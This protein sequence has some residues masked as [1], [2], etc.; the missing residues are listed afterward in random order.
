MRKNLLTLAAIAIATT[1][2]AQNLTLDKATINSTPLARHEAGEPLRQL[3]GKTAQ[4]PTARIVMKADSASAD[5]VTV[6]PPAGRLLDNM[7]VTSSGYGLGWGSI[8]FQNVDGGLGGVVEGDDGAVYVKAPISQAYVWMLGTPWIK[9]EKAEGDT[10]VMHTPQLYAIDAGDPYYIQRLTV[11]A[12]GSTYVVDSVDTD[13]RFVWRNDT[14]TQVDD[15]LAGLTDA[16]GEWFY[17]GDY[18]IVYTVN[19][20]AVATIPD[21]FASQTV[22]MTYKSNAADLSATTSQNIE[23]YADPE[24][25]S[26][27]AYFTNLETAL[28][29]SPIKAQLVDSDDDDDDDDDDTTRLVVSG[30][31]YLGID[32]TYNAHVYALT[33][34]AR[35]DSTDSKPFFNYDLVPSIEFMTVDEDADTARAEWPSALL[36]NCGRQNL[37][38]ISEFAAPVLVAKSYDA[39]V[40]ADPIFTSEDVR[41]STNFDLLH[42]TIPTT[43][44]DGNE[45]N[46]NALYYEIYLDGKPYT[47]TPAV[48]QGLTTDMT[49]IP[50]AF[51]DSYYDIINNNGRMTIYFYDHNDYDSIGVQSIYKAGGETNVSNIVYVGNPTTGISKAKATGSNAQVA[52]TYDIAGRRVSGNTRGIVIIRK[53]DGTITKEIK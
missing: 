31:Q 3:A 9:C 22:E 5:T 46:V 44:V 7:Y 13:I 25:D 33:A 48:F 14:L 17:M 45:M 38:I 40:P 27:E 4:Q 51:G 52:A 23:M 18:G 29:T 43:D 42:F 12:T 37:S 15:C 28:L 39:A 6:N 35:I 20:D 53:A 49:E 26:F 1:S 50:Y 41:H 16:T 32:A 30:G 2:F 47:F 11:D 19:N 21:G 24:G 34:A 8:Y 10:I 36:I